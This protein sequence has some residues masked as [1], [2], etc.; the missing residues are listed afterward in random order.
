MPSVKI[1]LSEI[2]FSKLQAVARRVFVKPS[3]YAKMA[4]MEGLTRDLSDIKPYLGAVNSGINGKV[5]G[6]LPLKSIQ[7]TNKKGVK[8]AY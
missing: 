3:V 7:K 1:T 8:N 5:N 2:E 4:F 6:G